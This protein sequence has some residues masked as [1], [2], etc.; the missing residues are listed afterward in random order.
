MFA[1]TSGFLIGINAGDG[2]RAE[3]RDL[4]RVAAV[5]C[6][7]NPGNT[8]HWEAAGV[9]VIADETGP[10]TSG[11]VSG[12]DHRAYVR[13]VLSL[14]RRDPHLFAVEVLNEPGGEWFWGADSESAANRESYA[15]LLIE[16]HEALVAGFGAARPLELA[17]WDGGHDSSNAWGE[18]WSRD[19]TAL[20]DVDGVTS[21]P[22]GGTDERAHSILGN[23]GLVTR[24]AAVSHKPVYI[25]EVGF[26][27]AGPTADSL[28]YTEA[29]QASAIYRFGLWA[30][31]R[32][33]VAAVTFFTYRDEREGGGYGVE[34]R[35]GVK[36]KAFK[37]L[38]RLHKGEKRAG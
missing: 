17:S 21:H 13:G 2:S 27:T 28:R 11:G 37:A 12:L 9:R 32:K 8:R 1:A 35:R 5:V 31:H 18:A 33:Y 14:V 26:P 30:E 23:R 24:A 29:E 7:S 3:V 25:T 20:A 36:K 38:E 15:R 4:R 22:Y 19:A 6:V 16:V 10:Y 34:T